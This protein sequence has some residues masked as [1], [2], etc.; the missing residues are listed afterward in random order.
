MDYNNL[1]A[2]RSKGLFKRPQAKMEDREITSRE[3]LHELPLLIAPYVINTTIC[4]KLNYISTILPPNFRYTKQKTQYSSK[5]LAF[6]AKSTVL[7][8]IASETS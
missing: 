3:E 1:V 8:L 5:I 7:Y 6:V 4:I 2:Q